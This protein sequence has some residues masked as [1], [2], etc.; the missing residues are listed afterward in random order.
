MK[1]LSLI[2]HWRLDWELVD[3]HIPKKE[4]EDFFVQENNQEKLNNDFDEINTNEENELD[5]E[6]IEKPSK[7]QDFFDK[8]AVLKLDNIRKKDIAQQNVGDSYPDKLYWIQ[9]TLSCM[10]ATLWLFMNSIPVVIWAMLISPLL[11]PIKTFAFAITTG[12]KWMYMRSIKT[13]LISIIIAII[14]SLFISFIVPFASLTSE[15]MARIS[16]TMVDLFVALFSGAVA[17]VSLWFRR[18]EENIAGVAMSVAL[19]PPLSVIWI[20]LFFMDLSVAQGSFLLFLANLVAILVIGI[21]IFYVF[22]F[23]PT[24]KE[25][26]KRSFVILSMVFLSVL[27]ISIPLQKSMQQIASNI[28]VTNQINITSKSYLQ[29]LSDEIIVDNINFNNIKSDSIFVNLK[30]NVPNDFV[31]TNQHKLELTKLLSASTQKSVKLNLNIVEVSSVYI[32]EVKSEDDVFIDNIW[33]TIYN[34]FDGLFMIDNRILNWDIKFIYLNLYSENNIDKEDVYFTL[35]DEVEAVYDSWARLIIQWQ[36]NSFDKKEQTLQ[37][38]DL[39]KQFNILFKWWELLSLSI[40][41][42]TK[43]LNDENEDYVYIDIDF[44]TNYNNLKV[45]RIMEEWKIM[46]ERYFE[47]KVIINAKTRYYSN[48]EI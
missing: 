2:K 39:E 20:G 32:D 46:L 17:F 8:I 38:S 35:M 21:I 11:N 25:W 15:V 33:K 10:I 45:K 37:E 34:T 22:G 3:N 14:S 4:D 23:F 40:D 42:L 48:L 9:F 27:V 26:Q 31:I 28:N 41:S 6:V 19:L 12:N 7:T 30:L 16:P 36:D 47:Q 13:L 44:M 18:L 24:N 29:N 5:N 1:F 43:E